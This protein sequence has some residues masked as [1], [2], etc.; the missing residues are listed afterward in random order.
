VLAQIAVPVVVFT[1]VVLALAAI[2]LLARRQLEPSGIVPVELNGQRRL[3]LE[4]GGTLLSRLAEAG[5]YL[6]AA[7][8]GRGTCGQCRVTV[9]T[10]AGPLLPTER[11]HIGATD[12]AAFT[13]EIDDALVQVEADHASM[14]EMEKMLG[15]LPEREVREPLAPKIRAP[16]APPPP[17]P[18]PDR[19]PPRR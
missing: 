14:E 13:A 6:A 1:L 9:H 11:V 15:A 18:P 2:V 3:E 12:A 10:G 8:G 7:C 19:N 4:A 17:P 16:V 5:V